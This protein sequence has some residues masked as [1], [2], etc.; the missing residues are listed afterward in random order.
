MNIKKRT[1]MKKTILFLIFICIAGILSASDTLVVSRGEV[2]KLPSELKKTVWAVDEIEATYRFSDGSVPEPKD[3]VHFLN[4]SS[5]QWKSI[6]ADSSGWFSDNSLDNGYLYLT[7]NSKIKRTAILQPWG[8]TRLFINGIPRIGSKYGVRENYKAW[9]PRW[10]FVELPVTLKKGVNRFLLRC[11]RS[12]AK[13]RLFDPPAAVYFNTKDITLPDLIIKEKVDTWGSVVIVNASDTCI[14]KGIITVQ[15]NKLKTVTTDIGTIQPYSVRKTGFS[16]KAAPITSK[17]SVQVKL[18]LEQN[19]N[20]LCEEELELVV[21]PPFDIHKRTFI[22]DIDE[23]VQYYAVNP[24]KNQKPFTPGL[25]FSV[26]G[27]G[28]KAVNQAGSYS[29]KSWAYVVAPTNRRPFGYD[30]E[31]WGRIDMLEVMEDVQQR[32]D[33]DNERIY[34]TGHS[35]GGHGTWQLGVLFPDKWAAI[36]PSAGWISFSSYAPRQGSE[37]SHPIE[38]MIQ[39]AGL[40]SNT[41][42]MS[43]NYKQF[44]IY[45]IHG[46]ED[47]SVPVS[48]AQNMADHLKEFHYDWIYHEEPDAGHWWDKSKE[49]G[50]DCVDWAPLFDFFARHARPQKVR[51]RLIDF[52]TPGPGVSAACHWVTIHAQKEP[53]RLSRVQ[54]QYDPNLNRFSGIT[55]NVARMRLDR[56]M[57]SACDTL[58]VCLDS[59]DTIAVLPPVQDEIWLEWKNGKWESVDAPGPETKGPHRNGLFKDGFNNRV[60]LVY[61]SGGTEEENNWSFAKARF[62]AE[63]FWYQGNGSVEVLKDTEF[64][65]GDYLGRNVIIYGNRRINKTWDFLLADV[66]VC[67]EDG[68]VLAGNK[69]FEGDNLACLFIYPRKGSSAASVGVVGGTG[70][71]G[72]RLTDTRPYL[73]SGYALPDFTLISTLCQGCNQSGLI[74]AGFFGNDWT[75]ANGDFQWNTSSEQGK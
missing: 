11:T 41:L 31:D 7:V 35:M 58:E 63:C 28:V 65:S 38:A 71:E 17:G 54:L 47:Q 20:V 51:T 13:L 26:H 57:V 45:I 18:T 44:G 50:A 2:I 22:S 73:Y 30:W 14:R 60:V 42:K 8:C 66:P 59:T 19:G 16:L 53:L 34:L 72:M 46:K 48:E 12:R 10:D 36:G 61:S 39:R 9:Q 75:V 74:G 55:E 3:T 40:A 67:I 6:K 21:K 5:A 29:A 62:D 1:I 4:G 25:I 32:Y 43:Q 70:I 64:L 52:S 56:S 33:I 27:A 69:K 24:A 49:P 15:G 23:S 68:F 37:S